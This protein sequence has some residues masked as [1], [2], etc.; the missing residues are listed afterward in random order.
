MSSMLRPYLKPVISLRA[1]AYRLNSTKSGRSG[2]QEESKGSEGVDASTS[3]SSSTASS[4]TSASSSPS[5]ISR[6]DAQI[7]LDRLF[8]TNKPS[9]SFTSQSGSFSKRQA[10]SNVQEK[11][12]FKLLDEKLLELQSQ[13]VDFHYYLRSLKDLKSANQLPYKFGANQMVSND[14]NMDHFL[15]QIVWE[16]NAPIRYA[17]GY[18]SKVFSQGKHVDVSRSQVDMILA[19]SYPDHWHSLNL[20]QFPKHYSGVR[21][22]G[23]EMIAKIGSWGAGVYF[24]PFVNMNFERSQKVDSD[25]QIKYGVTSIDNLVDDLTNWST[26]YLS[27]RMQKPIAVVRNAPKVSLLEQFNLTSAIKLAIL[28]LN[29]PE[30][31]ERELYEAISSISYLGDP[32]VKMGGENPHKVQNIV[33]G[34][35]SLFREMYLPLVKS[36]FGEILQTQTPS[37]ASEHTFKVNLSTDAKASILAELP[38]SFRKKVLLKYSDTYQSAFSKDP[39]SQQVLERLPAVTKD[40]LKPVKSHSDLSFFELQEM[41]NDPSTR[42]SE[43]P[44]EDWEY[45]PTNNS[46]KSAEFIQRIA[47][48]EHLSDNLILS[49]QQ[50]VGRPAMIQTVKGVLTAGVMRSVK[51]GWEKKRKYWEGKRS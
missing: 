28:L 15:R 9:W 27:G 32:R 25:F 22:L 2:R 29:K 31:K 43:I 17:F 6:D 3:Q 19:V 33:A 42:L 47:D 12:K 39:V 1:P 13:P 30:V 40:A 34:Q 16:F 26:M 38:L 23:S 37:G 4:A 51:Y 49:I 44:V 24:N 20:H 36:Y 21:I 45:I 50:T 48:D 10:L 41:A 35:F 14:P 8:K 7:L 18:G 5:P 46:Y 11:N